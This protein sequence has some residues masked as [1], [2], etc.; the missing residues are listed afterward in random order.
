MGSSYD[1]AST[2]STP[3]ASGNVDSPSSSSMEY[4]IQI[5]NYRDPDVAQFSSLSEL[6]AV[7][8]EDTPTGTKRIMLGTFS[9]KAAAEDALYKAKQRGF[10]EAYLVTFQNGLRVG[11]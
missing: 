9:D 11:R 2:S 5:G 10:G 8:A 3:A 7:E 6:G 4:K 1:T